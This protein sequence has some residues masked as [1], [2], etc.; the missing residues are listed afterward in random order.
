MLYTL[1]FTNWFQNAI[2]FMNECYLLS[3]YVS[4]SQVQLILEI[5]L[6]KM[7]K[8]GVKTKSFLLHYSQFN[9]ESFFQS[10]KNGKKPNAKNARMT[11]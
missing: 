6:A 8:N 9:E 3:Q 2:P 1:S 11:N 10:R 7:Q 4:F 5:E